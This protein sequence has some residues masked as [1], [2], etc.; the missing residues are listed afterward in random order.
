MFWSL[1]DL[2]SFC[3]FLKL[4]NWHWNCPNSCFR[5]Q[6]RDDTECIVHQ[7][8]FVWSAASQTTLKS[9]SR[10]HVT[11]NTM[12]SIVMGQML[13]QSVHVCGND[14]RKTWVNLICCFCSKVKLIAIKACDIYRVHS[15]FHPSY[16]R[17]H[18]HH[19]RRNLLGYTV[20]WTNTGTHLSRNV[21]HKHIWHKSYWLHYK[22]LLKETDNNESSLA[23]E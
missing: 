6:D 10:M 5:H 20:H 18:C 22:E 21:L 9:G 2:V 14:L 16:L 4:F 17:S 12:Q 19:H 7:M 15:F 8:F 3:N 11:Y 13:L 23:V 1:G